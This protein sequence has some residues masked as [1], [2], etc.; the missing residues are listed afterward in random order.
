VALKRRSVLDV[1]NALLCITTMIA[2]ALLAV[3]NGDALYKGKATEDNMVGMAFFHF[4]VFI[5][6]FSGL[7]VNSV[8]EYMKPLKEKFA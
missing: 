2:S 4:I 3:P 7:V 8:A 6:S 5:M 1:F